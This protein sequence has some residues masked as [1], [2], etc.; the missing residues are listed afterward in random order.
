MVVVHGGFLG[1]L[2]SRP[3]GPDGRDLLQTELPQHGHRRL[4]LVQGNEHDPWF[5]G[6]RDGTSQSLDLRVP[7]MPLLDRHRIPVLEDQGVVLSDVLGAVLDGAQKFKPQIILRELDLLYPDTE[8]HALLLGPLGPELVRR[9]LLASRCGC[10]HQVTDLDDVVK[11]PNVLIGLDLD[12]H[13]PGGSVLVQNAHG[14][15]HP[16]SYII[17]TRPASPRMSVLSFIGQPTIR[18]VMTWA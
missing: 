16:L 1:I 17:Q 5:L 9:L 14:G 2:F 10:R 6:F 13:A 7:P 4:V 18:P 12:P 15:S 8:G 3:A 11:V